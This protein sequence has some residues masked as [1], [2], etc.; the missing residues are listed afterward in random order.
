MSSLPVDDY[1]PEDR[2]LVN[3]LAAW[4]LAAAVVALLSWLPGGAV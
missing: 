2:G 1:R 3:G 4:L